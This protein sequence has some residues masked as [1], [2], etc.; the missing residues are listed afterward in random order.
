[1]TQK[2]L[3]ANNKHTFKVYTNEVTIEQVFNAKCTCFT[4]FCVTL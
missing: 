1:M 3:R 4:F 2:K